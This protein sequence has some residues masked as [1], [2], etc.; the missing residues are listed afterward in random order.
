MKISVKSQTMPER[1]R[2]RANQLLKGQKKATFYLR[3]CHSFVTKNIKLQESQK[4]KFFKIKIKSC[5][6]LYWS[7]DHP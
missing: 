6:A 1:G 2:E 7:T 4:K 3:Y 5:L